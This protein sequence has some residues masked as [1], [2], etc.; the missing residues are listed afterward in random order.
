MIAVSENK[1][2][3]FKGPSIM[4]IFSIFVD[5]GIQSLRDNSAVVGEI[6]RAFSFNYFT[7]RYFMP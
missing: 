2:Y 3:L 7:E 5:E 1:F 4:C 6:I